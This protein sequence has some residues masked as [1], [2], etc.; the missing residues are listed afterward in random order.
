YLYDV[1]YNKVYGYPTFREYLTALGIDVRKDYRLEVDTGKVAP[2]HVNRDHPL[3][4]PLYKGEDLRNF[5]G[6]ADEPAGVKDRPPYV[7]YDQEKPL[8]GEN[9]RLLEFWEVNERLW[10]I[11]FNRIPVF[12]NHPRNIRGACVYRDSQSKIAFTDKVW[13]IEFKDEDTAKSVACLMFSL[14]FSFF[15]NLVNS[16]MDVSKEILLTIRVPEGL[17]ISPNYYNRLMTLSQ[18]FKDT[19]G[20][21]D[22]TEH[23][24]LLWYELKEGLDFNKLARW[25][26]LLKGMNTISLEDYLFRYGQRLSQL[27]GEKVGAYLKSWTFD[28]ESAKK[29][30]DLFVRKFEDERY[31]A[32]K[33]KRI[34]PEDP[35]AFLKQYHELEKAF[36]SLLT[37]WKNTLR[38]LDLEVIKA[39]GLEGIQPE[40]LVIPLIK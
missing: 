21:E 27:R 33:D 1:L 17:R 35:D 11:A 25:D 32:I 29:V 8:K 31:T 37:E 3:A 39:Y 5:R 13:V 15:F 22:I 36:S 20:I 34:M 10:G 14:P 40:D 23:L 16:N 6:L 12:L 24:D 30:I 4:M 9:K 19:F 26:T 38:E 18:R 7:A 2:Y 28:T